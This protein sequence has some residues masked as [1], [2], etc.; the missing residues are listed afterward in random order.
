VAAAARPA[1]LGRVRPYVQRELPDE[2]ARWWP[3]GREGE[4]R[5]WIVEPDG[6]GGQFVAVR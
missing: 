5:F 4:V 2:E 6:N 1:L 3:A